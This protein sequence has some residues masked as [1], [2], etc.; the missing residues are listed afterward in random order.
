MI[1]WPM[2]AQSGTFVGTLQFFQLGESKLVVYRLLSPKPMT[3][4]GLKKGSEVSERLLRMHVAELIKKG[5]VKRR[6]LSD[7]RLK[8]EYSATPP[9]HL[10]HLLITKLVAFDTSLR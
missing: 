9:S 1:V 5:F 6:V 7:A 8:Y 10:A 3:I 2:K 4:E